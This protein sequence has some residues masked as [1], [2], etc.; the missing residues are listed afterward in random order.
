MGGKVKNFRDMPTLIVLSD[1][2]WNGKCCAAF[3][4]FLV[5]MERTDNKLLGASKPS[6]SFIFRKHEKGNKEDL[7][8][9]DFGVEIRRKGRV[10]VKMKELIECSPRIRTSVS[11]ET[12]AYTHEGKSAW[13]SYLPLIR[14][15][16]VKNYRNLSFLACVNEA[17]VIPGTLASK[18]HTQNHHMVFP[19]SP[20]SDWMDA[21]KI[22]LRGWKF[23]AE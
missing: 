10:Y 15:R 23:M 5:V 1:Y 2:D 19:E 20:S 4:R 9:R 21:S 8:T 18:F 3:S 12:K 7:G 22:Q 14:F 6:V 13:S 11:C 16:Q 17:F